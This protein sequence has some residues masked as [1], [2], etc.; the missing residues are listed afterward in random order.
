M[1]VDVT[2][3]EADFER[4]AA[5]A[6]VTMIGPVAPDGEMRPESEIEPAEED[7]WT[8]LVKNPVPSTVAVHWSVPVK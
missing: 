1:E 2:L 6:A 5:D 4:S 7:H 8:T 3:A